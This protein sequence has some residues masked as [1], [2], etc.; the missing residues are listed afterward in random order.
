MKR[1]GRE[2]KDQ[3][4]IIIQ[5]KKKKRKKEKTGEERENMVDTC[6]ALR[7]CPRSLA[8]FFPLIDIPY[9]C[10]TKICVCAKPCTK[11]VCVRVGYARKMC[12]SCVC[13]ACVHDARTSLEDRC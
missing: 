9:I 13:A 3:I 11:C 10:S 7:R 1:V 12:V 8:F 4:I 5:K 6:F 2:G